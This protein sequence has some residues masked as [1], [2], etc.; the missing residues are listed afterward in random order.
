D[1]MREAGA[2]VEYISIPANGKWYDHIGVDLEKRKPVY[3]KINRV[4]T[5]NGGQIY[6][7]T[8]KDYEPY[9]ITDAVHIGWKGWVY[10]DERIAQHMKEK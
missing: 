10:I 6:D 5:E 7:L 4:V 1:T 3:E 2:D 8:D 9:V